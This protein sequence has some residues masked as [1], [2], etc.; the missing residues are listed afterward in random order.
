MKI[1]KLVF[2]LERNFVHVQLKRGF[3]AG[4]KYRISLYYSHRR[5]SSEC[6]RGLGTV[7]E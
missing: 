6:E 7:T 2:D 3:S 5:R 4:A 1:E